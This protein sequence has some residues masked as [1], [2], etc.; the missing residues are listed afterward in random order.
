MLMNSDQ[1]HFGI[2]ASAP[3]TTVTKWDGVL[4]PEAVDLGRAYSTIQ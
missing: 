1:F 2:P 4:P 3:V